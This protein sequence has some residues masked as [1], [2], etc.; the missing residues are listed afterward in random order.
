MSGSWWQ[1]WRW[2]QVGLV[3]MLFWICLLFFTGFSYYLAVKTYASME[4]SDSS[5]IYLFASYPDSSQA[6]EILDEVKESENPV[7]ICFYWDGGIQMI[8]NP[9]YGR[10][11]KVLVAGLTGDASLYD[12]RGNALYEENRKGCIVDEK[13]A[14]ELFG[15][16]DCIGSIVTLE[17]K[18]YEI[19]RVVPW[20]HRV[21]LIHPTGEKIQYT[22]IFVRAREGENPQTAAERFLMS[23]GLNGIF[24]DDGWLLSVAK[25]SLFFLPVGIILTFFKTIIAQKRRTRDDKKR[26]WIWQFVFI[27]GVGVLFILIYKNV[28]IPS[29]WLPDKWSN[30]EFWSEKI[31]KETE[32]L[33]LYLMFPKTVP[34]VERIYQMVKSVVAGVSSLMLYL[35]FITFIQKK[36]GFIGEK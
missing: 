27:L 33:S 21:I 17:K 3:K 7:D 28:N 13:T 2:R 31:K 20:K 23:Y 26:Y 25:I 35:V 16:T 6:A 10:S 34:Q 24:V 9:N 22:R 4:K 30:F 14:L 8:E 12:W 29:D 5:A 1:V 15:S 36:S 11:G 18:Q 32:N 19:C